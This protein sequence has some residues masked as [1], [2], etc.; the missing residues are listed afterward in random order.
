MKDNRIDKLN[1]KVEK[2]DFAQQ[3]IS[4]ELLKVKHEL[5]AIVA[6]QNPSISVQE[7]VEQQKMKSVSH[8]HMDKTE[9]LGGHDQNVIDSKSHPRIGNL[10]PTEEKLVSVWFA[11][12]GILLF[13]FGIAFFIK[14]SFEFFS[15]TIR[16]LMGSAIGLLLF[17]LSYVIRKKYATYSQALI[18]GGGLTLYF[19]IFSGY[20]FYSLFSSTTAFILFVIISGVMIALSV[21]YNA[22]VISVISIIFA[23]IVPLL[24]QD[25]TKDG[26]ITIIF[27]YLLLGI[28]VSLISIK[29]HWYAYLLAGFLTHGFLSLSLYMVAMEHHPYALLIYAISMWGI[30]A[31]TYWKPQE[32]VFSFVINIMNVCLFLLIVPFII[33]QFPLEKIIQGIVVMVMAAILFGLNVKREQTKPVFITLAWIISVYLMIIPFFY[34]DFYAAIV[35][36]IVLIITLFL[37]ASLVSS[38]YLVI[39]FIL[40]C[41]S[42]FFALI[43][44]P[45][46][47]FAFNN[48]G[49][50]EF[51]F[52][53]NLPTLVTL[54]S[55]LV[56][57]AILFLKREVLH[58]L[59]LLIGGIFFIIEGLLFV[60]F[61][62]NDLFDDFNTRMMA[63]SIAYVII[64]ILLW[65]VGK[66]KNK[67]ELRI[68]SIVLIIGTVLKAVF[69]DASSLALV[70]KII[71]FLML[72]LVLLIVSF[73]N[74]KRNNKQ[75]E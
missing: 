75:V 28:S 59:V 52:F 56:L 15:P 13:V 64:S 16:V 17:L 61:Q 9:L 2:L 73:L 35:W 55:L 7:E 39:S 14:Y 34:Y 10:N 46:R 72:G 21:S 63:L 49:L 19:S 12:I 3:K 44:L 36:N 69:V 5:E 4:L 43:N 32:Y 37:I 24:I 6:Q 1:K 22:Q 25:T 53:F 8:H 20:H 62:I 51:I 29:M 65:T 41:L 26:T 50:E 58:K 42:S 23:F 54:C 71:I 60:T 67:K 31:F 18:G 27:Y 66:R 11:R 45:F 68:T 30:Y 33:S 74:Q 47:L 40:G 48:L 70:Y 57:F 38:H